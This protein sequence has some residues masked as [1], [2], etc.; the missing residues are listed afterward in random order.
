MSYNWFFPKLSII[1]VISFSLP[2]SMLRR[3][4]LDPLLH[5]LLTGKS[6]PICPS[7]EAGQES[8]TKF[9]E[10]HNFSVDLTQAVRCQSTDV[11]IC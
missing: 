2:V 1:N 5:S 7:I 11:P 9:A 8:S 6:Q 10:V 4:T 3:L